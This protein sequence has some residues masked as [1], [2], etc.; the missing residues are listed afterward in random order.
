MWLSIL[1][2]LGVREIDIGGK[3]EK[4][5]GT[6]DHMKMLLEEGIYGEVQ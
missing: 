4:E 2:L 5:E 6:Y 3:I 1:V